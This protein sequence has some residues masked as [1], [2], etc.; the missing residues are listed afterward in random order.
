MLCMMIWWSCTT[1]DLWSYHFRPNDFWY[2]HLP[3]PLFYQC[4]SSSLATPLRCIGNEVKWLTWTHSLNAL[5]SF[6]HIPFWTS[7]YDFPIQCPY[8]N[9]CLSASISTHLPSGLDV[10]STKDP[11]HS[12]FYERGDPPVRHMIS[13][14]SQMSWV[15]SSPWTS[16]LLTSWCVM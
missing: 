4:D 3:R 7:W 13:K 5:N 12:Q 6:S 9:D 15:V 8:A 14:L 1:G 2:Q 16:S 11:H 10:A